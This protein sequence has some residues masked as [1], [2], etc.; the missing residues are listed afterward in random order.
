MDTPQDDMEAR[1]HPEETKRGPSRCPCPLRRAVWCD[2]KH[3]GIVWLLDSPFVWHSA[4]FLVPMS[5]TRRVIQ[6]F[7]LHDS[8]PV[9]LF[10]LVQQRRANQC[11]VFVLVRSKCL[12][13]LNAQLSLM[14][15][16][17]KTRVCLIRTR[18]NAITACESEALDKTVENDGTERF[19]RSLGL[20]LE[21]WQAAAS[22]CAV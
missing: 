6:T 13:S 19:P 10:K 21:L 5:K 11:E 18:C 20:P 16:R 8:V 15:E 1:V 17:C 2:P 7:C 4:C 3:C 14:P 12:S 9:F 22:T